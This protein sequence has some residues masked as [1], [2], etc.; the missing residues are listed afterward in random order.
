V[1]IPNGVQIGSPPSVT[2]RAQVLDHLQVEHKNRCYNKQCS[3]ILQ[4]IL[5][6]DLLRCYNKQCSKILKEIL[7]ID[8]LPFMVI[9]RSH[10][11]DYLRFENKKS[12][13][14]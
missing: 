7:S 12:L 8:F 5:S 13:L 9:S 10:V 4:E 14:P 6:I 11:L 2:P 1:P 3:K